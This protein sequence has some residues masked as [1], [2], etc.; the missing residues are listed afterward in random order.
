MS[1]KIVPNL[2]NQ[3]YNFSIIISTKSNVRLIWYKKAVH[4]E[5]LLYYSI[6]IAGSYYTFLSQ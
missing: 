3:I 5:P 6:I 4:N 1:L 2:N